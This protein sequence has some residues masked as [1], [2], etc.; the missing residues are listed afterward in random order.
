MR[1]PPHREKPLTIM[2]SKNSL[3]FNLSKRRAI[4]QRIIRQRTNTKEHA[5]WATFF[6]CGIFA[7][8]SVSHL[9]HSNISEAMN[10]MDEL[11]Q[12]S[13]GLWS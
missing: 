4:L 5:Q 11:I 1:T 3:R 8:D 6:I 9:T 10:R 7:H 2:E 13:G 12:K